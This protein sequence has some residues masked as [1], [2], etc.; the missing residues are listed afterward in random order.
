MPGVVATDK[1]K[2]HPKNGFYFSDV[3]G[4][5]Y[6]EI[7]RSI[8]TH[9]I[10]DPLKVTP[11]YTIISGHQRW[12]IAKDLGLTHVPVEVLDVDERE[13]EY[14][15]IA[16]NVERRGEA[17]SDPMKKARIAKFLKEYWGVRDGRPKKLP[18]I[19]EEKTAKDIADAIGV[20]AKNLDRVLRLNELIPELQELVSLGKL[21]TCSAEQIAHLTPDEQRALLDALG[22]S[23][24][25]KTFAEVKQLRR[26]IEEE[27][28]KREEVER[29]V[30]ERIKKALIRERAE[31]EKMLDEAINENRL[32]IEQLKAEVMK[33]EKMLREL[34]EEKRRLE[35]E[36][37]ENEQIYREAKEFKK[38]LRDL[39]SKPSDFA[40]Y[41][42]S[43]TSLSG[44][45]IKIEHFLKTELAPVRYSRAILDCREDKVAM[46]NLLRLVE[47]VEEWCREMRALLP[48]NLNYIDAEVISYE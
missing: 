9:G 38:Q 8:A 41:V 37:R 46:E 6:E 12:R 25:N 33:K 39:Y 3:T 2:P 42:E 31:Y 17:E 14:L 19:E 32:F 22:E 16:E 18:Q 15:L 34:E 36:L 30:Q 28:K 29:S 48:K 20:S 47:V 24:T 23:L 4:E 45:H 11:D 35:E 7:K 40:R 43:A 5:K 1:L 26:A 44:L 13:A 27:R 10:R 21:G